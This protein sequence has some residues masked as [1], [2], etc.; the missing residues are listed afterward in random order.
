M[1]LNCQGSGTGIDSCVAKLTSW[2]IYL[3]LDFL[4]DRSLLVLFIVRIPQLSTLARSD[5]AT[6]HLLP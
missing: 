6:D 3:V 2:A 1:T 4:D 5:S